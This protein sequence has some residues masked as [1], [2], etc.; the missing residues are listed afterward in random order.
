MKPGKKS[1]HNFPPNLLYFLVY[2][3][4]KHIGIVIQMSICP[5][6]NKL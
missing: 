3:N 5:T 4:Y 6:G 1:F 2:A